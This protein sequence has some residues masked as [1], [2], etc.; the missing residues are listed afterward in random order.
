MTGQL[1]LEL[2]GRDDLDNFNLSRI[3]LEDAPEATKFWNIA[4]DQGSSSPFELHETSH[5]D[6]GFAT[7][8]RIHDGVQVLKDAEQDSYRHP[9]N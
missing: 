4:L 5:R 1:Q 7:F 8:P 6:Y 9:N 3:D 2:K